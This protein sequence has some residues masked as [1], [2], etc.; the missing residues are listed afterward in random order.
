M[1]LQFLA[2][3]HALVHVVPGGVQLP[4]GT[5][6]GLEVCG[7]RSPNKN[8]TRRKLIPHSTNPSEDSSFGKAARGIWTVVVVGSGKPESSLSLP[9]SYV[10]SHLSHAE[11]RGVTL[12]EHLAPQDQ[13]RGLLKRGGTGHHL[14]RAPRSKND[15][16]LRHTTTFLHPGITARRFHL[17]IPHLF[18]ER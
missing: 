8:G 7:S 18:S 3:D 5:F 16:A 17:C 14:K 6:G 2:E 13:L 10:N 9:A 12:A 11:L 4:G 15:P 1:L